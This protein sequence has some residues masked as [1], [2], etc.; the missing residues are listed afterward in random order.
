MRKPQVGPFRSCRNARLREHK[1]CRQDLRA[2]AE[3][4][5]FT[6]RITTEQTRHNIRHRLEVL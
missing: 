3:R 6:T 2:A 1:N 5:G 4:T